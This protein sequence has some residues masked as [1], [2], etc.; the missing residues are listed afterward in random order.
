[1]HKPILIRCASVE[2][3]SSAAGAPLSAEPSSCSATACSQRGWQLRVIAASILLAALALAVVVAFGSSSGPAAGL[4]PPARGAVADDAG[5][6]FPFDALSWSLLPRAITI[7]IK[8][9]SDYPERRKSLQDLVASARAIHPTVS[10]LVSYDGTHRYERFG[11]HG[12]E[13]IT[14]RQGL[15]AGRN[16]LAMAV[17]TEFL[18]L[19]DDDVLFHKGTRIDA[20]LGHLQRN[21]SLALVAA[22][23]NSADDCYASNFV[24]EGTSMHLAPVNSNTLT[25]D[26][27]AAIPAHV[28][29]NAFLARTAVLRACPWD[30]RQACATRPLSTV[31]CLTSLT[32]ATLSHQFS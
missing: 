16:C 1:M 4:P 22:C 23:Y 31:C 18:M 28:V 20:L 26:H 27:S 2:S 17:Q 30:P 13:Y 21:P 12:E 6:E 19:V 25:A 29:H 24:L 11:V 8:H 14:C 7:G 15:S 9:T 5:E 10:I 3:V 32:L